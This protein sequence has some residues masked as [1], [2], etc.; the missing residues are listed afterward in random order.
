MADR[1]AKIAEI[2]LSDSYGGWYKGR[3]I[4]SDAIATAPAPTAAATDSET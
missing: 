2:Q 3:R 1:P 4:M